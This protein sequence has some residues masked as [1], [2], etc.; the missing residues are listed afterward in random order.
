MCGALTSIDL[1]AT[2][3]S[4]V[5]GRREQGWNYLQPLHLAD[6]AVVAS[7]GELV[8]GATIDCR[9]TIKVHYAIVTRAIR[10]GK[11]GKQLV[12][13]IITVGGFDP[14]YVTVVSLATDTYREPVLS[15][16]VNTSDKLASYAWKM[17]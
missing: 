2:R 4:A 16:F 15:C 9:L 10:A 12:R 1:G 11:G 13:H 8:T 3:V 5:A 14:Q 7:G 6:G 17:F